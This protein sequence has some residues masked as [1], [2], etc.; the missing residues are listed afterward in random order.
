MTLE[1]VKGLG[2]H[3]VNEPIRHERDRCA[4]VFK[5]CGALEDDR[6]VAFSFEEEGK[7]GACD[8]CTCDED[9]SGGCD[10]IAE[11]GKG[12]VR[13]VLSFNAGQSGI[14]DVQAAI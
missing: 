10:A 6:V 1:A 13:K 2:F 12:H 11:I 8:A 3:V 14:E 9:I 4:L 7:D 5:L